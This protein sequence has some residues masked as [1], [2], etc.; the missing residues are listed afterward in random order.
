MRLVL[1]EYWIEEKFFLDLRGRLVLSI[2]WGVCIRS[3]FLGWFR[4]LLGI[5]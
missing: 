5:C 4:L 1:F 2:G 3:F